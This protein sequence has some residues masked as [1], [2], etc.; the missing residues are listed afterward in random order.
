MLTLLLLITKKKCVNNEAI[1]NCNACS[2]TLDIQE[3]MRTDV[4]NHEENADKTGKSCNNRTPNVNDDESGYAALKQWFNSHPKDLNTEHSPLIEVRPKSSRNLRLEEEQSEDSSD[5]SCIEGETI[6]SCDESF[7]GSAQMSNKIKEVDTILDSF[8]NF[9]L[10]PD[11]GNRDPK[12]TSLC[13]SRIKKLAS[14]LDY[15]L[16]NLFKRD[17]TKEKFLQSYCN[18]KKLEAG[19]RQAYLV[20]LEHFCNYVVSECPLS[21]NINDVHSMISRL[22]IW[23]GSFTKEK[24]ISQM[25]KMEQERKSKIT[26]D[27]INNFE[28]SSL[29]R[30]IVVEM[31]RLLETDT[32]EPV[33]RTSFTNIRDLVMTE[34]FIDNAHRAG[35]LANMTLQEYETHEKLDGKVLITVFKH[36]RAQSGPIRVFLSEKLFSWLSIYVRKVR[37]AATNDTSPTATVFVTWNGKPFTAT[38]GV[39]M[40]CQALWTKAGMKVRCGANRFRKAMV[41]T[42]HSSSKGHDETLKNDLANLMYYFMEDKVNSAKRAAEKVGM[43][44]RTRSK[45]HAAL[46]QDEDVLLLKNIFSESINAK[47][48]TIREVTRIHEKATKIQKFTIRQ[49]YD[50]LRAIIEE[51]PLSSSALPE[52]KENISDKISRMEAC[53]SQ[54]KQESICSEMDNPCSRLD[55]RAKDESSDK[56]GHSDDIISATTYSST[57]QHVFDKNTSALVQKIFAPLIRRE[58]VKEADINEILDANK[59][60]KQL[61]KKFSFDTIRNRLRY[62]IRKN[63]RKRKARR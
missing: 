22:Q 26:P 45:Q 8:H 4:P 7:I 50:K 27:D 20:S 34:I 42:V 55:N 33:N 43:I 58:T 37:S 16:Y 2:S 36:K 52:R 62:E 3:E 53:N 29:V 48:I 30:E 12:T 32:N 14:L 19:T 13:R 1:L 31:G 49:V 10:S 63:R 38:G 44:M 57:R 60:A 35:V 56:S 54:E 59:S 61:L 24:K 9:M 23:K 15:N 18:E 51:G 21:F 39:S 47:K 5:V 46:F 41:S 40:A 11:Y 6:S 17:F 25:K 28:S